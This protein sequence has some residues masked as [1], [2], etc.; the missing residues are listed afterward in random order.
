MLEQQRMPL[1]VSLPA[2]SLGLT[3]KPSEGRNGWWHGWDDICD[4]P[5]LQLQCQYCSLVRRECIPG[6]VMSWLPLHRSSPHFTVTLC[7]HQVLLMIVI[8]W[9]PRHSFM[10]RWP[11]ISIQSCK[12]NQIGAQYSQYT[13]W[14]QKY[15]LNAS[16]YKIETYWNI[17]INMGLQ[18]H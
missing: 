11:C 4:T 9:T 14:T 1:A 10:F 2:L 13:G 5:I 3:R 7:Y 6:R 8:L 12:L 15:S 16:S 17:F 18:I